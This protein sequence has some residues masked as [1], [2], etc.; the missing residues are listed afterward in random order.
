M[1]TDFYDLCQVI[2]DF[3]D[4]SDYNFDSSCLFLSAVEEFIII[5][6]SNVKWG[7]MNLGVFNRVNYNVKVKCMSY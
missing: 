1:F 4:H 5:Y 6:F 7:S 3:R 2:R